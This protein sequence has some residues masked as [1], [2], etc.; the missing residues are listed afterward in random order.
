[1]SIKPKVYLDACCFID[2]A[3]SQLS[4]QM[5]IEREPHV[6]YCRKFLEAARGNDAIV[7]TSSLSVAECVYV[8]DL[9]KPQEEQ[10]VLTE[11][12]KRLFRGMLLSGS[13]RSGVI[14]VQPTP[15]I[16]EGA[17]DLRWVHEITLKPMDALHASTALE[18]KCTHLVTTDKHFDNVKV[19]L[20]GMGIIVC[21]A[22]SLAHL[23]PDRYRQLPLVKNHGREANRTSA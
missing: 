6:F 12:V 21:T 15:L 3:Q 1:M 4:I 5:Q 8:K 18:M 7:F 19:E 22:D 2:M 14:P 11:E 20:Q 23:L 9:S 17:R 10:T 16:V 13:G